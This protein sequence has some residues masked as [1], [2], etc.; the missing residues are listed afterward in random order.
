MRCQL[1]TIGWIKSV[2]A[3][4][5]VDTELKSDRFSRGFPIQERTY[6]SVVLEALLAS[7]RVRV[8][9]RMY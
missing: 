8:P 5:R 1:N 2:Q 6:I 3:L 9:K 4:R 7:I